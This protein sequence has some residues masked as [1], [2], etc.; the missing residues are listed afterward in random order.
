MQPIEKEEAVVTDVTDLPEIEESV[1]SNTPQTRKLT[2][3]EERIEREK[4]MGELKDLG[5]KF[6]GLFGLSTDNFEVKQDDG[7]A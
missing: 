4:M 3:E 2:E 5:N 6:L 7:M 1:V